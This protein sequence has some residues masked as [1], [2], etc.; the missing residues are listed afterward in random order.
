MTGTDESLSSG[1]K[2]ST[3]LSLLSSIKSEAD[4]ENSA[5]LLARLNQDGTLVNL[6]GNYDY[7][8]AGYY[9]SQDLEHEQQAIR[10]TC[11][12]MLDAYIPPLFLEKARLAG[13]AVPE[14]YLSNG[15]LEPPVIV[16]PINPFTL[17]GKVILKAGHAKSIAKSLTRN[18]TYAI[19]CQE[20]PP[21]S[22]VRHFRA[23]LGWSGQQVFRDVAR[24]IWEQFDIPLAKVRVI[25]TADNSMLL[26]DLSPLFPEDLTAR[27]KCYLMERVAWVS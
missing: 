5:N 27:E 15:Y 17:K 14:Y 11:R 3:P 12:A 19:C 21:G 4:G 6:S 9:L 25:Q 23:V 8:S 26:S 22:K 13:L 2:R 20:I 7:L 16:D 1:G 18:F 10:P 24:Q